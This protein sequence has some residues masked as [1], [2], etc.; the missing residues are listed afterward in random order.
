M[1]EKICPNC[2]KDLFDEIWRIQPSED[3]VLD[4]YKWNE[5]QDFK[6]RIT[7]PHCGSEID[8]QF[9]TSVFVDIEVEEMTVVKFNPSEAQLHAY[10]SVP[11]DK[12]TFDKDVNCRHCG[13]ELAVTGRTAKEVMDDGYRLIQAFPVHELTCPV[14]NGAAE[15]PEPIEESS[16]KS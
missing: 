2:N 3:T 8:V 12:Y 16:P 1:A 15:E 7:C 13:K 5:H 14:C 6:E 4:A 10:F 9:E 11:P